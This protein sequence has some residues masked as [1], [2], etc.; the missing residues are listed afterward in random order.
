MTIVTSWHT[1]KFRALKCHALDL[2]QRPCSRLRQGRPSRLLANGFLIHQKNCPVDCYRLSNVCF[3]LHLVELLVIFLPTLDPA[4]HQ[5]QRNA[6]TVNVRKPV[7]SQSNHAPELNK[8]AS[9]SSR[10]RNGPYE[11]NPELRPRTPAFIFNQRLEDVG[12]KLWLIPMFKV[13][14]EMKDARERPDLLTYN[15]V[16]EALGKRYM[17]EEAEAM[18]DDMAGMRIRPDVHSFNY[19]LMVR[20]H[21]RLAINILL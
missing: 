14:K 19:L 4:C 12:N 9:S 7:R 18:F 21:V 11:F 1:P 20:S 8:D 3:M 6:A 5:Q 10:L 15:A 13:L 17:Y 16:L 2:V